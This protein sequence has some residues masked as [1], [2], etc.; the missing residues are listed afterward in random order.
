MAN[1]TTIQAR[2]TNLVGSNTAISTN[3]ITQIIQAEHDTI[4]GDNSWNDRVASGTITTMTPYGTGT[5]STSGTTITGT[6]TVWTAALIGAWMRVHRSV[7]Y[8]R[9]TDV[10]SATSLTL[11]KAL[12]GGDVTG[13]PYTIFQHIYSVPS[14]C[15]R[16]LSMVHLSPLRDISIQEI[17][18]VD[19]YRTTTSSDPR[20][21]CYHGLDSTGVRQVEL[22]PV[23]ASAM[24]LRMQYLKSNTL[25]GAT[26]KPLYRSDVL[27]WKAGAS[28][29]FLLFAKTG[30]AA[31][32]DLATMYLD[33]YEKSLIG[34]RLDDLGRNSPAHKIRD[35]MHSPFRGARDDFDI[36]H[37]GGKV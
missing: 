18:R 3:E 16:I 11:E 20:W 1:L 10:A 14:D 8:Y 31:W 34:A 22:W 21:F 15:E 36:D 30:D 12:A 4:L 9:I 27:V 23:P 19:P 17:D 13:E 37:D 29:A 2:V 25:T 33:Q 35:V 32:R 7:E 24:L 28:A 5:V 6:G 26:D